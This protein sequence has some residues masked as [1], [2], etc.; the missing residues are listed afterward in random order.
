TPR[1]PRITCSSPRWTRAA[2][3]F[4]ACTSC[5]RYPITC[6]SSTAPST[7]SSCRRFIRGALGHLATAVLPQQP[8]AVGPTSSPA[9]SPHDPV[10][11]LCEARAMADSSDR[12]ASDLDVLRRSHRGKFVAL[13]GLLVAAAGL[14]WWNSRPGPIGNDEQAE[15]VLV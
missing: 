2:P 6:G 9:A 3:D 5:S 10:L 4:S 1:G 8:P 15:R 12:S 14:V 13:A 11:V 7:S